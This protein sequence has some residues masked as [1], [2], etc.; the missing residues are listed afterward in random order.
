M[1]YP[2]IL[3]QDEMTVR[4]SLLTA[5]VI[6]ESKINDKKA[7]VLAG[8]K[9]E[10]KPIEVEKHAVLTELKSGSIQEKGICYKMVEHETRMVG[11]YNT[12]G[13][14]VSQRP[15]TQEDGQKTIKMAVNY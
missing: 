8:F 5:L 1:D 9:A 12:R 13:Q 4:K 3:T 15:M 14:L 6:K 10:L 7:E 11:Y 2:V